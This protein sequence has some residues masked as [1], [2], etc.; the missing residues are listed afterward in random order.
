MEQRPIEE[1]SLLNALHSEDAEAKRQATDNWNDHVAALPSLE[2]KIR[3]TQNALCDGLNDRG[4]VKMLQET[5]IAFV[6]DPAH[7]TA[8]RINYAHEGVE[9]CSLSSPAKK[10]F[11]TKWMAYVET[12]SNPV[13][14]LQSAAD[15][16]HE[17]AQLRKMARKR[18]EAMTEQTAPKKP[19]SKTSPSRTTRGPT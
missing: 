6:E 4:L 14:T 10:F 3:A 13:P 12:L 11:T 16:R 19:K 8:Q 2:E 1:L 17:D 5:W 7:K 18:L 9:G 15:N